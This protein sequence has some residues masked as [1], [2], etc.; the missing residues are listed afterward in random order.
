MT[1]ALNVGASELG[2]GLVMG[3]SYALLGIGLILIFRTSRVLHMGYGEMGAFTALVL[4]SLVVDHGMSWWLAF[5]LVVLLG[6][7]VGAG[8]E[9]L[10][11]RR[12]F[13]APRLVL[14]AATIGI[15]QVMFALQLFI[16]RANRG[17]AALY[18]TPF[19]LHVEIG[20]FVLRADHVMVLVCMPVIVGALAWTLNRTAWGLAIRGGAENADAA[21]LAGIRVRRISTLVWALGGA[22]ATATFVLILPVR[23]FVLGS[24]AQALGP[25]LLLRALAVGLVGRME[26]LIVAVAGGVAIGVV[27]AVL[28]SNV[29]SSGT[30]DIA[31]FALVIGLLVVRGAGSA[32]GGNAEAV[33]GL[34]RA[35]D[36]S[37]RRPA[38]RAVVAATLAVGAAA[39]FLMSSPGEQFRLA[40]IAVLALVGVSV[41]VITGW[42]GQISLCQFTLVGCG[43]VL[44]AGLTARGMNFGWT[45]VY[46]SVACGILAALVGL[47]ALRIRGL[48]LAAAT[49]AFAVAG[50]GGLLGRAVFRTAADT[51]TVPRNR[52]GFLNLADQRTYYFVCVAILGLVASTLSRLRR[53][54]LGR[55]IVAV[56]ENEPAAAAFGL[57]PATVKLLAFTLSGAVAG[58]AGALYGGLFV[59]LDASMFGPDRSFQ[60]LAM[61]IIGGITSVGGAL[62]GAIYVEGLPLLLGDTVQARALTT[63]VGLLVLLVF[64]PGGLVEL[65]ARA[66][67]R[68]MRSTQRPNRSVPS[69]PLASPTS[70]R[71]VAIVPAVEREVPDRVPSGAEILR[72][73]AVEVRFDGVVANSDVTLEVA[74]GEVLGLIGTNGAGKSTLLNAIGGHVP[75]SSGTIWAMGHDIT[76]V[77]P[78]SRARLGIGR[79]FQDAA[80]FAELTVTECV[81][82]ALEAR[83]RT[84]AISSVLNLPPARR[85]ERARNELARELVAWNGLEHYSDM[86]VGRLST[87]TRRVVELTCLVGSAPKL[88][89]LDEPTAGV[90]QREVEALAQRLLDVKTVLDATVIIIEHDMPMVMSVCDRLV[91]MSAGRIIAD[92]SP[93]QVSQA[94]AVIAAYL[95]TDERA[96]ARSDTRAQTKAMTARSSA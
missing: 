31:F 96:I 34:A 52:V 82:V 86:P 74:A 43:A 90:A 44:S 29:F 6:A 22:L 56:R 83:H 71:E 66:Y 51:L 80:L 2:T 46:S 81:L 72:C 4:A 65:G 76:A 93:S 88:I 60:V 61:T 92:G 49:L 95:G 16:P 67:G 54:G 27:E 57:P 79:M 38:K 63:G 13:D 87:G 17:S 21:S 10:I 62:V 12:L 1:L 77:A 64:V 32:A 73:K 39:P 68:W 45:L 24:A 15:G 47:P 33:R 53:T 19:D 37:V 36:T 91:C 8:W 18:P 40:N 70:V 78:E 26:S 23:G 7:A 28:L 11:V 14:L 55:S 59:N 94:P 5:P 30:V 84:E 75:V 69:E 35:V 41:S 3:L 9:L 58:I 42:A 89:L 48:F 85:L 25:G 20:S 50:S